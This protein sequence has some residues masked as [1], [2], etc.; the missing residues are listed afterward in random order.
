MRG[1]EVRVAEIGEG[2]VPG[3]FRP[4]VFSTSS[5]NIVVGDLL[6]GKL[7]AFR[8]RNLGGSTAYSDWSDQIV[9]RA[10]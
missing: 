10:A 8:G 2:G 1:T 4:V 5:R 6:P 7:Y 9:Q 3:P